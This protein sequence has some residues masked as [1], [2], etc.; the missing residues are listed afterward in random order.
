M[1]PRSRGRRNLPAADLARME[2]DI[3]DSKR[4]SSLAAGLLLGLTDCPALEP[5]N[6]S[7]TLSLRTAGPRGRGSRSS[8]P[9]GP[10]VTLGR[11]V[12]AAS[13]GRP[14]PIGPAADAAPSFPALRS[15]TPFQ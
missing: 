5:R 3:M 10:A 6:R 13:I 4:F 2:G 7:G 12:P 14:V 15:S 11:P 8:V 9:G 1:R